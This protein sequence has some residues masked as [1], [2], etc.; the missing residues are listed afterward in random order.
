MAP[1]SLSV[2]RGNEW[3][4]RIFWSTSRSRGVTDLVGAGSVAEQGVLLKAVDCHAIVVAA[5]A[6]GSGQPCT[7]RAGARGWVEEVLPLAID[8]ARGVI[9]GRRHSALRL[10]AFGDVADQQHRTMSAA[11]PNSAN[12]RTERICCVSS[13]GARIEATAAF[14]RPRA[15]EHDEL[16][17]ERVALNCLSAAGG[18]K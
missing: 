18:N 6:L 3:T 13:V 15:P 12:R 4:S 5:R 10:T 7:A 11:A 1:S 16:A 14:E 9:C 2:S 8:P 17:C